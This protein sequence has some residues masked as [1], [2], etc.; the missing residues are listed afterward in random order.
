MEGEGRAVVRAKRGSA[1]RRCL[2]FSFFPLHALGARL[3]CGP[4]ANCAADAPP[5]P[6]VQGR[7]GGTQAARAS[8]ST[9]PF[10]AAATRAPPTRRPKKKNPTHR[11]DA[12]PARPRALPAKAQGAHL[13]QGQAV[14]GLGQVKRQAVRAED[15]AGRRGRP[16]V[17][18]GLLVAVQGP[19]GAAAPAGH[20]AGHVRKGG[21]LAQVDGPAG[22]RA[23]GGAGGDPAGGPRRRRC[24]DGRARGRRGRAGHGGGGGRHGVC[25]LLWSLG[26]GACVRVRVRRLA[27]EE[28][29][30]KNF[31]NENT[32]DRSKRKSVFVESAASSGLLR[33]SV[34]E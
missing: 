27:Q 16:V 31:A 11:V 1:A 15:E 28:T 6:A 10:L 24:G 7:G 21:V 30:E 22:G 2:S 3:P 20:E 12:P 25:A 14:R 17:E 26:V 29:P 19:A 33:P 8:L 5:C 4:P 32:A 18:F 9:F 13:A 23:S 34:R